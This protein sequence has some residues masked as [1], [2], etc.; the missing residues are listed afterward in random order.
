MSKN[1]VTSAIGSFANSVTEENV[2]F[3]KEAI[4]AFSLYIGI[5]IQD[6]T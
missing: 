2:E 6:I 3:M 1:L 4:W 5:K